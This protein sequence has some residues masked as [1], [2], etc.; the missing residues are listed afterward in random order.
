MNSN[1]QENRKTALITG[2]SS[3]IGLSFAR[4]L[5][6]EGYN[7]ILVARRESVL[8]EIKSELEKQFSLD[9]Q[10]LI[11]DLS[12]IEQIKNVEKTIAQ[13][14]NLEFLINAAGFGGWD[15]VYPDNNIDKS[16]SMITTHCIATQ[17][18]SWA[19]GKIMKSNGKGFIINLASVAAYVANPGAADY[20]ATKSFIL[21]FTRNLA[22]DLKDSGVRVQALCPGFVRTNF[23]SSPEM[24]A[25]TQEYKRIPTCLWLDVDWLT[26][27]SLTTIQRYKFSPVYIPSIRYKILAWIMQWIF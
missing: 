7:L 9:I 8:Q 18:L 26:G 22:F 16:N 11:A 1:Q 19:G 12:D 3:G 21:S 5:A 14:P 20:V 24:I 23:Y 15:Q 4:R 27:K 13:T 6:S 25:A 2:A 10:I 17:R